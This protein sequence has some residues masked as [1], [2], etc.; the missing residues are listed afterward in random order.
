MRTAVLLLGALL[1]SSALAG[2]PV[3]T[4]FPGPSPNGLPIGF[5][6]AIAGLQAAGPARSAVLVGAPDFESNAQKVGRVFLY[7]AADG[8]LLKILTSPNATHL[9]GFGS[10]VAAAPDLNADGAQDCLV[11]APGDLAAG[12]AYVF[13]RP[14]S[15]SAPAPLLLTLA[16]PQPEPGGRFGSSLASGGDVNQDGVPDTIVGAPYEDGGAPDA[17]RVHVL[18]GSTG[19]PLLTILSPNPRKNGLFGRAVSFVPDVNGDGVADLAAGAPGEI[20]ATVHL[21]DG[22]TGQWLR[23]LGPCPFG[24]TLGFQVAGIGDLDGDGAGDLLASGA[25]D[26]GPQGSGSV[27]VFSGATGGSLQLLTSP[28]A[29]A[30]GFFGVSIAPVPDVDGDGFSEILVGA[31]N[32]NTTGPVHGRAYVFRGVDFSLL[33]E[34]ETRVSSP[35]PPPQ[36]LNSFGWAVCPVPDSDGDGLAEYGVG[37]PFESPGGVGSGAA[38]VFFCTSEVEAASVTRP[39]TPPNPSALTAAGAPILGSTWTLSLDDALLLPGAVLDFLLISGAAAN[40]PSPQGTILVATSPP[41]I[42]VAFPPTSALPVTVP[43]SCALAGVALTI[44][45]GAYDGAVFSLSNALDVI[46]GTY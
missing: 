2:P 34:L 16:S 42:L 31:N 44:Q 30:G 18:D 28:H 35:S 14:S 20:P 3:T 23:S 46:V 26:G 37:S 8:A 41:P 4:V 7:K 5:G 9:G 21:F 36:Y 10:A 12:R 33:S 15:A 22:A 24:G 32:E 40:I 27:C 39:G 11:G 17:G 13:A 45:G 43:A 6:K 29:Q 25:I 38:Y 19:A 1:P